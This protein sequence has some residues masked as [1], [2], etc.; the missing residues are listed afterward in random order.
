[1][2][3]SCLSEMDLKIKNPSMKQ[4]KI[5]NLIKMQ[6]K[7]IVYHICSDI[8]DMARHSPNKD[9][10]LLLM[11][12]MNAHLSYYLHAVVVSAFMQETYRN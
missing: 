9:A 4:T 5:V 10:H 6:W 12:T 1:M 3:P 7:M 8:L 2:K 11:K